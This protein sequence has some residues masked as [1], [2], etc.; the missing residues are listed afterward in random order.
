MRFSTGFNMAGALVLGCALA[1]CAGSASAQSKIGVAAT[2]KNQ[3]LGGGQV[4]AAGGAIHANELI[5]TGNAS[6]AQ[7]LFLDQT[8]L[9]VGALSEVKLDRFVYDPNSGNGKVVLNATKGVFRFIS[10]TQNKKSYQINTPVA[11]IGVRGTVF[12]FAST[13]T[14]LVLTTSNGV[15]I[16]TILPNGPAVE[17][18][19]GQSIVV[20]PDGTYQ[21][22]Q[23]SDTTSFLRS[24]GL[25][26]RLLEEYS[27][28]LG[29]HLNQAGG[30]RPGGGGGSGGGSQ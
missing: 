28:V 12:T 13:G 4:L 9:T 23:S 2:V 18:P 25:D 30:L 20:Y 6:S 27:I 21:K 16:V 1:L 14:K 11:T 8:S 22:F 17:V 5:K 29:E 15:V 26:Q 7:L 3:V 24:A 10:G 19:A